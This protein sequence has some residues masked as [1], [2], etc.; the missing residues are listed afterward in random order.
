MNRKLTLKEKLG[1]FAA[2]IM[3]LSIGMIM[4]GS[5]A[6]NMN[7]VYVGGAVFSIGGA[8]AIWLIIDS[9]KDED[10]ELFT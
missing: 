10:D 3:F 4:G 7:L 8:I 6:G 2:I 1:V 9:K 5:S